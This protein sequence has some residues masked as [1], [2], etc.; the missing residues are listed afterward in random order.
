M[1]IRSNKHPPSRLWK[2]GDDCFSSSNVLLAAM[3]EWKDFLL[4]RQLVPGEVKP[5]LSDGDA[6]WRPTE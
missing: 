3:C 5:A 4:E 6:G 2:V 1:R